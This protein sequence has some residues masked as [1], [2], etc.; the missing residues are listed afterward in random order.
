MA[1]T[2]QNFKL[3]KGENKQL[4]IIVKNPDGTALALTG[5]HL[6]YRVSTDSTGKK[7][8]IERLMDDTHDDIIT[9]G[10]GDNYANIQFVHEDTSERKAIE[11]YHELRVIDPGTLVELVVMTGNWTLNDS[12][13]NIP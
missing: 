4:T 13:T 2:G 10:V 12:N 9:S 3:Y 7:I 6:I 5:K 11:A 1:K 8:L